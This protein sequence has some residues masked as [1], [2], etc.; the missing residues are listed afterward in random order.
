MQY[1]FQRRNLSDIE[2]LI[3]AAFIVV[4]LF[5]WNQ[6]SIVVDP[7]GLVTENWRYQLW[8]IGTLVIA[9]AGACWFWINGQSQP[10]IRCLAMVLLTFVTFLNTYT[11]EIFG[12]HLGTVWEVIDSLFITLAIV[13]ALSLW[14][15]GCASGRVVAVISVVAGGLVFANYLFV[16]NQTLWSALDPVMMLLALVWAAAALSPTLGA[17]TKAD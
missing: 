3:G 4:A 13:V 2:L 14:R 15:C 16:N 7:D 8:Q 6:Q 10:R 5:A 12:D 17:P 1:L 9:A 11:E